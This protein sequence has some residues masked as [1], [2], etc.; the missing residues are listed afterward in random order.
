M[1]AQFRVAFKAV[2]RVVKSVQGL[3]ITLDLAGDG[4]AVVFGHHVKGHDQ[5]GGGM[6]FGTQVVALHDFKQHK[7]ITGRD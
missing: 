4:R 2:F 5:H 1:Q 7:C 6:F 3:A